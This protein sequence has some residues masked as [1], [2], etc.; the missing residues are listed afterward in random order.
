MCVCVCVCVCACVCACAAVY[1]LACICACM[2]VYVFVWCLY[3][4]RKLPACYTCECETTSWSQKCIVLTDFQLRQLLL[5]S[6]LL[7]EYSQLSLI[8]HPFIRQTLLSTINFVHEL[9][10]RL[11]IDLDNLPNSLIYP[12]F[13]QR[14]VAD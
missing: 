12:D 13:S 5:K 11:Q 10:Q 8:R 9:L 14:I 7:L 4:C 2:H 1:V 6:S 3:M